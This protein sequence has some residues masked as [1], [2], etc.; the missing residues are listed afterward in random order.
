MAAFS[1]NDI[2]IDGSDCPTRCRAVP[3]STGAG[4]VDQSTDIKFVIS[5][6]PFIF[7]RVTYHVRSRMSVRGTKET[8]SDDSLNDC[9]GVL[10]GSSADQCLL[11]GVERTLLSN[12]R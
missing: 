3:S 6:L 10:S 4:I 9:F 5:D 1:I 2:G 8:F 12:T 7:E 11:L